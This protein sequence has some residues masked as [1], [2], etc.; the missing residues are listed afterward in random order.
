ML[1]N[2]CQIRRVQTLKDPQ[3]ISTLG[4][5]ASRRTNDTAFQEKRWCGLKAESFYQKGQYV[6]TC[7][8]LRKIIISWFG[9]GGN[10]TILK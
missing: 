4:A 7:P 3:G 10:I 9:G 2:Y 8:Y 1:V 6:F 5:P